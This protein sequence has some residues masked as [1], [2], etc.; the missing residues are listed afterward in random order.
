[1][2]EKIIGKVEDGPEINNHLLA[3]RIQ[4]LADGQRD[5][6]KMSESEA[7]FRRCQTMAG[8]MY[9]EEHPAILMFNGNI[10]TCLSL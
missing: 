2:I 4:T 6:E 1:M 3:L 8:N 5:L 9:G 10:V 7:N